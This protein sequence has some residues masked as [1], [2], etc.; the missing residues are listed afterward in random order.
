MPAGAPEDGVGARWFR[1]PAKPFRCSSSKE[2]KG[3]ARTRLVTT[4]IQL[5]RGPLAVAL[6]P[7]IGGAM[8]RMTFRGTDLLRRGT[9]GLLDHGN[10][11]AAACFP[12]VPFS[13]RIADGRFTFAGET[14]QL[15]PNFPPEPHA[16]HGQ[17]WMLPWS[18]RHQT[19]EWAELDLRHRIPGTPFAYEARQTFNLDEA[20]LTVEVQVI[21]RGEGP[22]PA[23]IGLHPYFVRSPGVSLQARLRHMWLT[24]KR[25]IP[26]ERVELPGHLD[27]SEPHPVSDIHLDNGFDGWDGHAQ[28]V[29]PETGR[30]ITLEADPVFDR[31][32]IYVPDDRDFFCFE[33]ASHANNGFNMLDQED[34]AG[35]RILEPGEALRGCVRFLAA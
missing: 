4:V 16:I 3:A 2:A 5:E 6:V 33:P 26:R 1:L 7:E 24:D 21:N 30:R 13:G 18:V 31:A 29:W 17:G 22:M 32:V 8:A 25:K 14:Y 9:H 11:R 28:V 10:V 19:E 23:G 27:F 20:Q 35:V 12:L 15:E 34:R